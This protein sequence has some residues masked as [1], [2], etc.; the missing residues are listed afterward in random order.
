MHVRPNTED[1]DGAAPTL[2]VVM[3]VRDALPF[4]D[5]SVASILSQTFADFEFVILD[6]ASTDGSAEALRRWAEKDARIRLYHSERNLGLVGSSNFVVARARAPFVARMDADD[7]SHPERL[8]RQLDVLRSRAEVALVGTLYEGIDA[9]G[10]RVRPR[11]RWR[12]ARGSVSPPFPHGSAMFRREVF[13]EVGGYREACDGW[14]DEDLFQRIVRRRRVVV[15][16]DTLYRYRFHVNSATARRPARVMALR[17]RCLA[18]LASGRDYTRLLSEAEGNGRHSGGDRNGR[19]PDALASVIYLR[20]SM[21]LWAGDTPSALGP[22]CRRESFGLSPRFLRTLA[23]AA[24]GHISPE[25]LRLF[26]RS[27]VR[28]RDLLAGWRVRDGGL[29]EWRLK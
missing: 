6:D 27:V 14:E 15:L 11:D 2:S 16:T 13:E 17:H 28:A 25:S 26:L 7:V 23:W 22:L 4:L 3:P 24:W 5:E 19:D 9:G 29:Y 20:G 12:L 10:R 8:H 1:A 21:R 18:E